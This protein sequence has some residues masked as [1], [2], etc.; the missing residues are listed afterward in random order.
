MSLL[1]IS[2][3]NEAIKEK[4][5][6]RPGDVFEHV[7]K[8]LIERISQEG[9]KDGMDGILLCFDRTNNTLSYCAANN[10][11]VLIS[12]NKL[13]QL[14]CDKMP[15]GKGEKNAAFSTHDI[16]Y[17]KGDMLY[18]FTDGYPDQ[19]G[20]DKGKKFK[21]KQFEEL[22]LSI[23]TLP[24]AEQAKIIDARFEE[25]KGKLEQIDDVCVIGIR[26]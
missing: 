16:S 13:Q 18:V 25:W 21:Y 17:K 4:G 10:S 20:G 6:A 7:R 2:F 5:L 26:L 22:L 1:N 3:L 23:H 19:F 11:P 9:R 15:V 12:E 24:S 14:P 8:R